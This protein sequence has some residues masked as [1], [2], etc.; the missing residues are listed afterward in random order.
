MW[1][2]PLRCPGDVN[3]N[4]RWTGSYSDVVVSPLSTIVSTKL[5]R[6]KGF[7]GL[8]SVAERVVSTV[9]DRPPGVT[10]L[11]VVTGTSIPHRG[12]GP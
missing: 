11:S 9:R 3:V 6:L 12:S 8:P 7:P 1:I 4:D 10:M 2:V 5:V